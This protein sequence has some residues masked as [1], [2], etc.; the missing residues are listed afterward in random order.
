[1]KKFFYEMVQIGLIVS[2]TNAQ[3]CVMNIYS[4]LILLCMLMFEALLLLCLCM[5]TVMKL[6]LGFL[7]V[8]YYKARVIAYHISRRTDERTN[9]FECITFPS[10]RSFTVYIGLFLNL[11]LS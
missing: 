1:M 9:C 8:R 11:T 4:C 5:F 7:E 6:D 3:I 10:Y 2:Q